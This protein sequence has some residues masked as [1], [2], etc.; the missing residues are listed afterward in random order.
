MK[1]SICIIFTLVSL[2]LSAQNNPFRR[3]YLFSPTVEDTS[4][5]KQQQLLAANTEGVEDRDLRTRVFLTATENNR[6]FK[7]YKI[8]PNKFTFLLIGKD[9]KEKFRATQVVTPQLLFTVIDAMPMR[10]EELRRRRQ[11][12]GD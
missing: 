12:S 6:F 11:Q 9:G 4:L 10:Q 8:D 1:Y 7:K 5:V 3:I 2:A